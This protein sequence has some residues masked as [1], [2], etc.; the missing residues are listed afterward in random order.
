[1]EQANE[2]KGYVHS[3]ESFWISRR[4][5]STIRDLFDRMRYALSVLS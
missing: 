3:L 1:M 5:G 2:I 4:T